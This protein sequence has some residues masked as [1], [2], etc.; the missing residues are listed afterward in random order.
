MKKFNIKPLHDRVII[1]LIEET[2]TYN[3]IIIPE[4]VSG[5]KP[6]RGTVV[7][8]G[9]GK[10]ENN[11]IRNLEVKV[12]DT[13]LFGKYSGSEIKLENKKY[14]VMREEDVIGILNN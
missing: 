10:I 13:V 8:V 1:E 12:G 7:A 11:Q 3:G 5:D 2:K 6:Q 14:L 9:P 4:T